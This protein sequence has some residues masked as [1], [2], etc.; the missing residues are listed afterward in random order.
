M[1]TRKDYDRIAYNLA[2][3]DPGTVEGFT[4]AKTVFRN[5]CEAV[6]DA[7]M[8]TNPRFKRDFFL[9]A[10]NYDYWKNRKQP[11]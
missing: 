4:I 9:E 1:L 6:A 2:M 11:R 7:L 10:C 5:S 3:V 8:G